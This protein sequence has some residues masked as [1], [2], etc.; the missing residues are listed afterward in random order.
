VC[1]IILG[2]IIGGLV[3]WAVSYYFNLQSTKKLEAVRDEIN[4]G[5][6]KQDNTM[7]ILLSFLKAI[8][9]QDGAR[10]EL[11]RLS[12]GVWG[13]NVTVYPDT[14]RAVAEGIPPT[15]TTEK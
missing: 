15:I 1:D 4:D 6:D 2:A 7:D 11:T 13:L 9:Q 12:K 14:A 5:L 3:S 10:Y 8:Q